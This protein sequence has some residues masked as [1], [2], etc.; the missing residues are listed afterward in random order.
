MNP[1]IPKF[2]KF[3]RQYSLTVAALFVVTIFTL[4]TLVFHIDL[5]RAFVSTL[6]KMVYMKTEEVIFSVILIGIM[7]A[8]D[9]FRLVH[10]HK[11]KR[12]VESEK[13]SVARSTLASVHDVVNN[14]LNN[15]LL[16]KMEADKGK[17]LSPE[18]LSL[19]GNLIDNLATEIRS[20]DEMD[21]I[22]E[23]QLSNGLTVLDRGRGTRV[24]EAGE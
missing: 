16:V 24:P 14:S 22:S 12:E 1:E 15:M 13:L 17:P 2:R 19:F 11:R 21:I 18:T 3:F 7:F 23:R 4:G 9:E 20:L 10:R 6:D 5:F 8:I